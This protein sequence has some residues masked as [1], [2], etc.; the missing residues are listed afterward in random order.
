MASSAIFTTTIVRFGAHPRNPD[1]LGQFETDW[2]TELSELQGLD[3][4]VCGECRDEGGGSRLRD[5]IHYLAITAWDNALTAVVASG[6][7]SS[8]RYTARLPKID[9][10]SPDN[11]IP[12]VRNNVRTWI[13][14][15][16]S[17]EGGWK[18]MMRDFQRLREAVRPRS[19]GA[20]AVWTSRRVRVYTAGVSS[21]LGA[22]H[23]HIMVIG[24]RPHFCFRGLTHLTQNSGMLFV[25]A[26]E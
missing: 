2:R 7:G 19:A 26:L 15:V 9:R 21:I 23:R 5:F 22:A 3:R 8:L 12:H 4:Y 13:S 14:N 24:T 11:L 6:S 10:S 16:P 17:V 20:D 25:M 1:G 18:S